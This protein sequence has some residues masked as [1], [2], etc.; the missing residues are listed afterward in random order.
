M[1][2]FL[3]LLKLLILIYLGLITYIAYQIIFFRQKKLL[4]IKTIIFFFNCAILL[5][6]ISNKYHI[7]LFHVYLI[8]YFLGIIIGKKILSKRILLINKEV[9]P[10][11]SKLKIMIKKLLKI[12]SIPPFFYY[13]KNKINLYFYYKKYPYLKPK[14]LYELFWNITRSQIIRLFFTPY[15]VIIRSV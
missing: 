7:Y 9:D 14:S 12:I 11:I 6:Y 3:N 2:S 10:L 4:F 1:T 5:I 15:Y 13:A 8:F